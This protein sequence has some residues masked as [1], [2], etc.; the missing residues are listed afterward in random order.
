MRKIWVWFGFG[1]GVWSLDYT[2]ESSI[3]SVFDKSGANAEAEVT[4]ATSVADDSMDVEK[5][6]S[7]RQSVR[8]SSRTAPP[9]LISSDDEDRHYL[10]P[11]SKAKR[12]EREAALAIIKVKMEKIDVDMFGLPPL[13]PPRPPQPPKKGRGRPKEI[14]RPM[15][16]TVEKQDVPIMV[17]GQEHIRFLPS[18]MSRKL[19]QGSKEQRDRARTGETQLAVRKLHQLMSVLMTFRYL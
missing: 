16:E 9:I 8:V 15:T 4:S 14:Q 7:R 6:P 5:A 11:E 3:A 19:G 2:R 1:F 10:F 13:S 12:S 17:N 18:L